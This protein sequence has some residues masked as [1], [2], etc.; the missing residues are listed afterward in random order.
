VPPL[1]IAWSL[2]LTL[3]L[4]L[5]II[6]GDP[7]LSADGGRDAA[8]SP[9][10]PRPRHVGGLHDAGLVPRDKPMNQRKHP[11]GAVPARD[12]LISTIPAGWCCR[13]TDSPTRSAVA[14]VVGYPCAA[15]FLG[16]EE[17]QMPVRTS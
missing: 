4:E 14:S 16:G 15:Y 11:V 13:H 1:P 7:A 8:M 9:P 3:H 12:L 5:G 2:R 6:A 17:S 10:D